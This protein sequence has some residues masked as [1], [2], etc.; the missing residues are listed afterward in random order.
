VP[1]APNGPLASTGSGPLVWSVAGIG[2]LM[3]A[4][5]GVLLARKRR[6]GL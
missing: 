2:A 4:A 1:P 5:G 6:A 3:I